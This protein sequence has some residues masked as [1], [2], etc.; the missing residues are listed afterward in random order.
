MKMKLLS[1]VV[2]GIGLLSSA[3]AQEE[4]VENE[5]ACKQN[6]YGQLVDKDGKSCGNSATQSYD[7]V[8]TYPS[9]VNPADPTCNYANTEESL[10]A[11]IRYVAVQVD[12]QKVCMTTHAVQQYVLQGVL[13]SSMQ[14]CVPGYNCTSY[15]NYYNPCPAGAY[16]DQVNGMCW[17]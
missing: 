8:T 7:F 10:R 16:Y 6:A 14:S 17:Y 9:Y 11:G 5:S 15:F 3:F 4:K 13:P 1:L 12:A 2:V